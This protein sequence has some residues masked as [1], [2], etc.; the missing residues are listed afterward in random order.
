L[1]DFVAFGIVIDDIVTPD[2]L[3]HEGVL[4]GGGPQ[5]AWGMAAA[6]GSGERVGLASYIGADFDDS[7]LLPLKR[8]G[9]NLEGVRAVWEKTPR[10]WQYMAQDGTRTHVWRN[11]PQGR[12]TLP[13]VYQNARALHWGLHPENP[14][15]SSARELMA[16]DKWL[17]L[18]TFK[19]PDKP[20]SDEALHELVSAC[21]IFSP[22]WGEAVQIAGT[23]DYREL[24][25]RF[26]TAGCRVLALRRGAH[27]ADVWALSSGV[28]VRVPAVPTNVVDTVG[29]GNA[30]CGAL[31]AK[32]FAS[33]I[34]IAASCA[35]AAASYMIEQIGMPNSLPTLRDYQQRFNYALFR[36]EQLAFESPPIID[37]SV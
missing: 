27:G 36:S 12:S 3:T 32:L 30:F 17:S 15:L 22:N 23:D 1:V 24:L 6:L 35:V 7:W 5:T 16:Q 21:R 25:Q 11:P 34:E 4:G 2:G 13:E 9:I 33:T 28:G 8:A 19:P 20:M 31:L 26:K 14:D 37:A 18:E 29:A 10:A